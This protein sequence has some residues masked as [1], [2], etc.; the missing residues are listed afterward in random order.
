MPRSA[1]KDSKC[2]IGPCGRRLPLSDY[3]EYPD[4]RHLGR[5]RDCE[6]ER[7]KIYRV[8]SE[9]GV[10]MTNSAI[11]QAALAELRERHLSEFEAIRN[12]MRQMAGQELF[13]RD[14]AKAKIVRFIEDFTRFNHCNP[15]RQ[16]VI[17]AFGFPT[18]T[19]DVYL[20]QMEAEGLI[21]RP[22]AGNRFGIRLAHS[23]K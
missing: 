21:M 16:Q 7:K 12:R 3:Y 6:R 20:R 9:D 13:K 10:P 22:G 8:R 4:G 23:S 19:L 5:C 14:A 18:S 15:R 1:I 11:Y 2:C 17:A